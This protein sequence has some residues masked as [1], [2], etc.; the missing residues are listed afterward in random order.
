MRLLVIRWHCNHTKH[1]SGYNSSIHILILTILHGS[2]NEVKRWTGDILDG[3]GGK[4]QRGW[5][6]QAYGPWGGNYSFITDQNNT[7]THTHR[8]VYSLSV[9][10]VSLIRCTVV[11][12]QPRLRASCFTSYRAKRVQT[13]CKKFTLWSP[14]FRSVCFVSLLRLLF[15]TPWFRWHHQTGREISLNIISASTDETDS[16]SFTLIRFTVAVRYIVA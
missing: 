7:V 11:F 12:W 3:H 1:T 10:E 8:Y 4:V 14:S 15:L 5:L 2:L 13:E 6:A 16:H 9:W